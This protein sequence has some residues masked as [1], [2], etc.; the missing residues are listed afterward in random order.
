MKVADKFRLVLAESLTT[1]GSSLANGEREDEWDPRWEMRSTRAD[2]DDTGTRISGYVSYGGLLMRLQGDA[3]NL[4]GL[5]ADR[6]VY[7]L[8]KKII[9]A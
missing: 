2:D 5:R 4:S 8:M 3:Q 1:D 9:A 6:H 7:L